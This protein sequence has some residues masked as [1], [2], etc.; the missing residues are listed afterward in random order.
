MEIKIVDETK[1]YSNRTR[2]IHR[3]YRA[4]HYAEFEAGKRVHFGSPEIPHLVTVA[5]I[6]ELPE[7]EGFYLEA[8]G[9]MGARSR[10]YPTLEKA[11]AYLQGL[12]G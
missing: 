5:A 8:S 3:V 12:K 6:S 2:S 7:G 9:G 4:D 10:T 11:V 1:Q